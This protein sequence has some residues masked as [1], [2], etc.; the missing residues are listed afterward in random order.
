MG[1][2]LDRLVCVCKVSVQAS[3][4]APG[5]DWPWDGLSASVSEAQVS[6]HQKKS[7]C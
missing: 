5:I 3:T 1:M 2:G 7:S 6:K 4:L